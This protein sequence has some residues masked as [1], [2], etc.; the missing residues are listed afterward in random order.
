MSERGI[1]RTLT[2]DDLQRVRGGVQVHTTSAVKDPWP[3]MPPRDPSFPG[4]DAE[5]AAYWESQQVRGTGAG[6]DAPVLR[7]ARAE[8]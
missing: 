1:R 3:A 6:G 7:I 8:R 4:D 2:D 5:W